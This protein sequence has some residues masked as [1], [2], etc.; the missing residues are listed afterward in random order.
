MPP[1]PPRN[2]SR[3]ELEDAPSL[4]EE[5]ALLRK[6]QVESRQVHLLLVDLDLREVGV[7]GEVGGEA[8]GDAVLHV[9]ADVAVEVVD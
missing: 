7:V 1:P 6:E 8:L 3:A 4:E 5:L 9:D 2:G